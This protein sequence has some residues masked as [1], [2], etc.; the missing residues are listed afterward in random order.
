MRISDIKGIDKLD[1]R[2]TRAHLVQKK[3]DDKVSFS[4]KA[5]RITDG[6]VQRL[7]TLGCKVN[8]YPDFPRPVTVTSKLD[9]IPQVL[10]EDF[11]RDARVQEVDFT[12]YGQF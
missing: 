1:P 10:T 11:V 7:N 5:Q 2:V 3:P 9:L 12:P 4:F 6:D 8:F